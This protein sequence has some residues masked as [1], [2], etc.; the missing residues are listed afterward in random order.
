MLYDQ[1][2]ALIP[3]FP[4]LKKA[5]QEQLDRGYSITEIKL[6]ANAPHI[7][8]VDDHLDLIMENANGGRILL[9]ASKGLVKFVDLNDLPPAKEQLHERIALHA[10]S[11]RHK[12]F[13]KQLIG[14]Y[15]EFEVDHYLDLIVSDYTEMEKL[16]RSL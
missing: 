10:N 8:F 14:G 12:K 1:L 9:N 11:V 13:K 16:L 3:K 5:Y 7:G 2:T 4:Q 15:R 6:K